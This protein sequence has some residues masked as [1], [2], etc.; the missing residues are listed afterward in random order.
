MACQ[1]LFNGV[2]LEEAELK[3][4]F[5]KGLNASESNQFAQLETQSEQAA[6]P[7]IDQKVK[8]FLASI[9]VR[10]SIVDQLRDREGKPMT[11]IAMADMLNKIIS[12]VEGQADITTLPE[13]AAHFFVEML[14]TGSPLYKEMYDKVTSYKLYSDVVAAYKDNSLYRNNDGTINFDKLKKEAIGKIIMSYVISQETGVDEPAKVMQAQKWWQKVWKFITN[15]FSQAPKR[16]GAIE[17]PFATAARQI[18]ENDTT[19]LNES[20]LTDNLFLQAESNNDFAGALW[21]KIKQDQARFDMDN[22]KDPV[23]GKPKHVYI[24]DGNPIL[25]A[26]GSARSVTSNVVDP[27]YRSKFPVDRR[28]DI[29]KMIDDLKAEYGTEMHDYIE[30]VI[31]RYVDSDTGLLRSKPLDPVPS[32]FNLEIQGKLDG[33][34]RSLLASYPTGTRFMAEVRLYNSRKRMPGTTD[35]LVFLKDG[36][37]D[38]YDWKSQE[39]RDNETELKWFKEP[40]YRL[41]LDEYT[42]TLEKEYGILK[43]NKVRAIPIRTIFKNTKMSDTWVPTDLK[44]PS[45]LPE[46]KEYLL[47]VVAK[48][49]STG[50][51]MLDELIEK[52]NTIYDRISQ[53]ST[54]NKDKKAL[55]LNKLKKT[56]RTLQIK[57]DMKH[58]VQSG[59]I[60]IE[61]YQEKLLNNSLTVGEALEGR[62]II[63]TYAHGSKYLKVLLVRLKKQIDQEQDENV[64]RE[65]EKQQDD[66]KTMALNAQDMVLSL[67]TR[68]KD[69]TDEAAQREGI[70]GILNPERVMDWLKRNFRSLSTLDT[71]GAQ[72]LNRLLGRARQQ[73]DVEIDDRFEKLNLLK[74]KLETWASSKGIPT[75]QMFDGILDGTDFLNIYSKEWMEERK[76]ALKRSDAKWIQDNTVFDQEAYEAAFKKYKEAVMSDTYSTDPI[77]DKEK[78]EKI[79]IRWIETHNGGQSKIAML[80]NKGNFL[81]PKEQWFSEKYKNLLKPENKPLKDAYDYF[82]ELLRE[83]EKAGMIDYEFGFIPSLHKTK[84][85]AFVFGD[86][87]NMTKRDNFFSGLAVDSAN[88]FGKVD[89][90]NGKP[91]MEI[92]VYFTKDLGEQKSL[93][94][95]KVFGAWAAQTANYKAMSSIEDTANAL[96]FVEQNK[97]SLQTNAFGKVKSG[98]K[99]DS[100]TVNATIL[101]NHIKYQIYGQKIDLSEDKVVKIMGKEISATRGLQKIMHYFSLKTLAFNP[102]SGTAALVG[103]TLNASF[104][105]GKDLFFSDKDWGNGMVDFTSRNTEAY[106]FLDYIAPELEDQ[107]YRKTRQLSISDAVKRIN[108]EDFFIIQR[109]SDKVVIYPVA[110]AMYRSHMVDEN[111]KIVYIRDYVK[112]KYDYENIYNLPSADRKAMM[113]KIDKEVEELKKTSSLKAKSKIVDGKLEIEGL[114]RDSDEVMMFR[115][116]IKKVNKTIIGNATTEDINQIRM[117]MMGQIFMQFRSWIPQMVTERFGDMSYDAELETYTYGKARTFFKHF[118]D[119]KFLPLVAELITG[120]GT[121]A[122]DRAKERYQEMLIR[123]REAGD[124][125]FEDRMTEAQFIDMYLANLRS[126]KRELLMLLAFMGLLAWMRSDDDEEGR[127]PAEKLMA[128]AADKY[129]NELAFFYN[130]TEARV[131]LKSP[132]PVTGLL[133]D[134]YSFF[135]HSSSQLMGF[136]MSDEKVMKEAHPMKYFNKMFPGVK[137]GQDMLAIFDDDFRKEMGLR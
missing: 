43:F 110:L 41:Q 5:E 34:M 56:I 99:I 84:L 48:N 21:N 87:K 65:L 31:N 51:K 83:S 107:Q 127:T 108:A 92:P 96:L 125:N 93:D 67:E 71:A 133:E 100:N 132:A 59:L 86:Y 69:L 26:D 60:E 94:L 61:K 112:K 77:L 20:N 53:K 8:N 3:S 32:K 47:P 63:S 134:M 12:V 118:F 42:E 7:N 74:E 95:F 50:D 122:I 10:L 35:L 105:A 80:M 37:V 78:K 106:G 116:K 120:Y 119:K 72:M 103:G 91:I 137:V 90:L 14:G 64:K 130:P 126:M 117:G 128:R 136:G 76:K 102:I 115:N 45:M 17:N 113:D 131:L 28:S 9:G 54:K 30:K 27:W 129:F 68:A 25:N 33:Y 124:F 123:R 38:V 73:R 109:V 24:R 22:S 11:G 98:S 135:E 66:Y 36:S 88:Q 19:G 75:S 81:K 49:E 55:E 39:V 16:N 44:D 29:Q 18:L 111:G 70:K 13:E 101:E 79:I 114:K 52:L 2:W 15:L 46:S 89:P 40:A 58:F 6:D 57:K 4:I 85:E 104:I 23:T 1:Y 62:E 82:Q 97:G 121:N